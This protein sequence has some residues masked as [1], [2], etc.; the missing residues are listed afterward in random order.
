MRRLVRYTHR[1]AIITV[2]IKIVVGR[3]GRR[4]YYFQEKELLLA[5]LGYS[6]MDQFVSFE[7][8]F[9]IIT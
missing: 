8:L 1:I 7:K 5:L 6:I 3:L 4:N 2:F 9:V